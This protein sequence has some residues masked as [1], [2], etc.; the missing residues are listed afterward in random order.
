MGLAAAKEASADAEVAYSEQNAIFALKEEQ[1]ATLKT[2]PGWKDV[3]LLT[4]D[5]AG[6]K[7][8][9]DWSGLIV[10]DR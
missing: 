10:I 5:S 3:E 2:F 4:P 7:K 8:K 1:K 6:N 9:S